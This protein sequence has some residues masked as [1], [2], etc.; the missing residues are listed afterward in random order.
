VSVLSKALLKTLSIALTGELST[1][2]LVAVILRNRDR[3]RRASDVRGFGLA[4]TRGI[5]ALDAACD[6][7]ATFT[8]WDTNKEKKNQK[9]QAG[10]Q[11]A[12]SGGGAVRDA[13]GLGPIRFLI[14]IGEEVRI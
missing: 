11:C 8:L 14:V 3:G 4:T 10:R 2:L 9:R 13:V 12:I 5:A 6:P 1:V 7:L